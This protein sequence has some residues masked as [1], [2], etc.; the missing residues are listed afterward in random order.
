MNFLPVLEVNEHTGKDYWEELSEEGN[1]LQCKK[2][3]KVLL[4]TQKKSL[5]RLFTSLLC[6]EVICAEEKTDRDR[7][8]DSIQVHICS[9]HSLETNTEI[10]HHTASFQCSNYCN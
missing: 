1:V 7:K 3:T 4:K 9:F 6:I 5:K 10:T 2:M 8:R